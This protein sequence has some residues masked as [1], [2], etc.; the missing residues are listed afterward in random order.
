M[1]GLGFAMTENFQYYGKVIYSGGL[2]SEDFGQIYL[3]RGMLAPYSHPL[4]TSMT[5]IGL[6]AARQSKNMAVKIIAPIVGFLLAIFLHGLWN[7]SA[8][9]AGSLSGS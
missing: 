9:L 7:F 8:M 4:F 1:I 3:L 2:G 6:G 5:G